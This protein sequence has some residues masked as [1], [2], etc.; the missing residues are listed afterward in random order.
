MPCDAIDFNFNEELKF[1]GFVLSA[2]ASAFLLLLL[3]WRL[4]V[5]GRIH[6]DVISELSKLNKNERIAIKVG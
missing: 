5:G 6:I 2:S 4:V 1:N 3:L